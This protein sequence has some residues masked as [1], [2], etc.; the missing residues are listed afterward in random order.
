[1]RRNS[2][3]RR[4]YFI[5]RFKNFYK[6]NWFY[7]WLFIL[8]CLIGFIIGITSAKKYQD[9]ITTSNMIDQKFVDYLSGKCSSFGLT[10]SY[11]FKFLFSMVLIYFLCCNKYLSIVAYIVIGYSG[12][13]MGVNTTILIISFKISGIIYVVFCYVPFYLFS[14]F[15]LAMLFCIFKMKQRCN[16]LVC[17]HSYWEVDG[18]FIKQIITLVFAVFLSF[19]LQSLINSL[20]TSTIIVIIWFTN[21]KICAILKKVSKITNKRI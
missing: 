15:V 20:T 11:F 6:Q 21:N 19:F 12:F 9:S 3:R 4:N 5:Q 10:F 18:L 16:S 14:V 13:C 1:M 2:I 8:I 7:L 17:N